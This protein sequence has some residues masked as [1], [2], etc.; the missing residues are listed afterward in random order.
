MELCVSLNLT[1][2]LH[3]LM[4]YGQVRNTTITA[5]PSLLSRTPT[6]E[7]I[8]ILSVLTCFFFRNSELL[9]VDI[10]FD[11][12]EG[13]IVSVRVVDNFDVENKS[14]SRQHAMDKGN[15]ILDKV[16]QDWNISSYEITEELMIRRKTV[17]THLKKAG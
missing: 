6:T 12:G 13:Q 11:R 17:L 14:R 3:N 5:S 10:K 2:G 9:N 4:T 8:V 7:Q 15:A 16:E 1:T